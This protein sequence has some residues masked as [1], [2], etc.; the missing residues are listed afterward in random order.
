MP[1]DDGLRVL[2]LPPT[3]RDRDVLVR[4]FERANLSYLV[5]QDIKALSVEID[6]DVGVLLLT[7]GAFAHREVEELWSALARQP[8]WSEVPSIVLCESGS[9]SM[10]VTRCVQNLRNVT[11][12]EKPTSSRTLISAIQA[13]LRARARQYQMRDQLLALQTSE[14]ALLTATRQLTDSNRRKDEFLAMLAHEL[15][16]PLAPIMNASEIMARLVT[17]P[18]LQATVRLLKRQTAHLTR[19]VDD[20]L[21]LSRITSGRIEL[22]R[23][24]LDIAAVVSQAR[25]IA[26]PLMREKDHTFLVATGYERMFV[27]GDHARLVQSIANLLNNA[28]KYTDFGRF[29]ML[30]TRQI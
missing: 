30:C 16:N 29:A 4:L 1:K 9:Q 25:E 3:R 22:R 5:C 23:E 18:Q 12:L 19:L 17:E 6:R 27:R 8:S 21:D 24:P 28:A 11:V 15:R 13:G 10:A 20:L 7:D 14:A 2:F 26:E